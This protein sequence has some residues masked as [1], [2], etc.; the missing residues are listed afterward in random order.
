MPMELDV[1]K[2][3]IIPRF[4]KQFAVRAH[5]FDMAA[6]HHYDLVGRQDSG[7][8]LRDDEVMR[9]RGACDGVN[10]FRSGVEASKLDVVKDGVVKQKCVLGDKTNLFS[11]R[12]LRERAQIAAIDPDAA[13]DRIV[14]AQNQRQN[15]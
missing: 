2:P 6:V 5:L 13:R 7:E 11:Q 3:S 9:E 4:L 10:L 14:Q 15:G 12:L 8:P 1:V